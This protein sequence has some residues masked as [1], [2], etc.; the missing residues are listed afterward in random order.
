MI[1]YI[2]NIIN[3]LDNK[4]K[5]LMKN[6]FMFSFILIILSCIIL[7]T[8]SNL[9]NQPDLYYIGLSLFKT[10]IFFI[11]DFTICGLAFNRIKS[12]LT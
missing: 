12:D 2:K 4:I 8:Y 3:S 1:N 5:I 7:F 9:Y 10:S 11:V 6:G